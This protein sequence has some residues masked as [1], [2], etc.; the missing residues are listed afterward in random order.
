MQNGDK[1]LKPQEES[2]L[3]EPEHA[4]VPAWLKLLWL[5]FAVWVM[6]YLTLA[7]Y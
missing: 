4:P 2:R 6:V 1:E 3:F 5:F 7:F